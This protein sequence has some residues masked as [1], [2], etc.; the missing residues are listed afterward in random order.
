MADAAAPPP[1]VRFERDYQIRFSHCD[2]AGI[3]FF[4]QYLV[5]FNQ[6]VE[7]WFTE[8]L[9]ISYARLLGPRRIGLPIVRLECDF[10]AIGRMGETLTFGLDVER[11]GGKIVV[12]TE[13]GSITADRALIATNAYIDGLEPVTS[14]HVMPI[15]SFIGATAPLTDF[16]HIIPGGESIADSRFVVRYFRKTKD[17][18]LLFGGREAYTKDDPGDIS[19]HIRRQICELYPELQKIDITHA[20]GGF[21]GI[22]MPRQPFVRE[23]M[24]GVTSIGGY[25]GHGVMLSN[26]CGKLYADEILGAKTDLDGLRALK[27]PAF[28]GGP[29][30]RSPL[31]FLALTW[32]ALRD[33]F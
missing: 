32:Y 33:R 8:G 11:V 1:L 28:P 4:P 18:R 19:I 24:P 7:D 17:N 21:V 29:R 14:A 27:I 30:F 12:E 22:T 3:V 2:P 6:L 25:S 15:G 5:L 9:G 20:W 23:V 31:L 13:R 10:R 26:Y 16:P